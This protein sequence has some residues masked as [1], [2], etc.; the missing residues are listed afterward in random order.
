MK[1]M[2]DR[3]RQFA[4]TAHGSQMYG[5]RPYVA[6]LDEVAAITEPYWGTESHDFAVMV[7]Y[8]HDVLE[9]TPVTLASLEGKF[10]PVV[11]GAVDL[12]SDPPG[13]TRQDRKA[14]MYKRLSGNTGE[15]P[16]DWLWQSQVATARFVKVCDRMANVRACIR[17]DRLDLLQKYRDEH[18]L[19]RE[20]VYEWVV[21]YHGNPAAHVRVQD[22]LDKL[23][24]WS[25]ESH[26]RTIYR[27]LGGRDDATILY[28]IEDRP[29][30]IKIN[31]RGFIPGNIRDG[32]GFALGA[33]VST[34]VY[35]DSL[36][37]RT[38]TYN[39]GKET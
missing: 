35:D 6:H 18:E 31:Y 2:R 22:D 8:L 29:P 28:P 19:F 27:V 23:I 13:E 7:A 10:D 39:I 37:C 16:P 17:Q 15:R 1:T 14:A 21:R 32:L 3:A 20:H 25:N 38:L 26:F 5:D 9:D 34:D 30:L 24:E 11:T 36:S 12:L 33:N 4:V